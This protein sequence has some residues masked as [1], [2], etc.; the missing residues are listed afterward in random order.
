M[1]WQAVVFG[2]LVMLNLG[3]TRVVLHSGGF[4]LAQQRWQ[5]ALIWLLPLIGAA[6]CVQLAKTEA[7]E[8]GL[9]L[10]QHDPHEYPGDGAYLDDGPSICS[11]GGAGE[12]GD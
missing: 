4:S 12:G 1:G 10:S 9:V 6:V 8:A 5:L 2:V 11:C 7:R 3:A